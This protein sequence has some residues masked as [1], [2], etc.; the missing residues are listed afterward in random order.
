MG[1][2]TSSRPARKRTGN[3]GLDAGLRRVPYRAVCP[4]VQTNKTTPKEAL[5]LSTRSMA[6]KPFLRFRASRTG[7]FYDLSAGDSCPLRIPLAP[8]TGSGLGAA[9]SPADKSGKGQRPPAS[10]LKKAPKPFFLYN[11]ASHYPYAHHVTSIKAMG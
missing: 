5:F 9:V 3:I 7:L 10:H 1:C 4:A 2:Y 8:S 6:L 11:R